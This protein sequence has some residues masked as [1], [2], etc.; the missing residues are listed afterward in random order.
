[1]CV[2]VTLWTYIGHF[3]WY[4]VR[5]YIWKRS[6]ICHK[7]FQKWAELKHGFRPGGSHALSFT[8]QQ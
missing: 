3:P 4:I 6:L 7:M 8:L 2:I 5:D 1:M